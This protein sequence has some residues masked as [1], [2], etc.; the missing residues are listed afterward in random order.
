MAYPLHYIRAQQRYKETPNQRSI[1]MKKANRI[2]GAMILSGGLVFAAQSAGAQD[3]PSRPSPERTIPEKIQPPSGGA[4][5]R[6]VSNLS[7]DE[8]KN[9]KEALKAKGHN[10]GPMDTTWDTKTQQA[11]RD[12]QQA[13]QLP[14]TG[15]LD[16][17]TAEK[18]GV[19]LSGQKGLGSGAGSGSGM[20]S[21][22]DSALPKSKG[23]SSK[24]TE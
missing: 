11:L 17:K 3:V 4:S 7:P 20:K 12:F 1:P 19:T 22:T 18:L 13:N 10:P 5:E 15:T 8:I 23:G 24:T 21:D 2:A 16:A 14:A 9:A 6:S